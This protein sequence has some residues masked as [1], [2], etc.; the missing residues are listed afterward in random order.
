MKNSDDYKYVN[1][2]MSILR[3]DEVINTTK[4]RIWTQNITVSLECLH[5]PG[6]HENQTNFSKAVY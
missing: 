6:L 2:F 3:C 1:Y 4:T 5:N